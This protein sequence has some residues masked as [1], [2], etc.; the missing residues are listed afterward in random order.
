MAKG[1]E[2]YFS[3]GVLYAAA[4]FNRLNDQPHMCAELLKEAGLDIWDCTD[5][6]EFEKE[7]LRIINKEKGMDLKGL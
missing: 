1:S 4:L 2:E 6:D 7:H 5:L 3:E